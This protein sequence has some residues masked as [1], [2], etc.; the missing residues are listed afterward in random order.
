LRLTI[1][2]LLIGLF[3]SSGCRDVRNLQVSK[4]TDDQ[5]QSLEKKL[6]AEESGL[7]MGYMLRQTMSSAFGGSGIPQDITIRQAIEAQRAFAAK[8]KEDEIKADT[9]KAKIEAERK[10]KQEEF[11]KVLS[12]A[13]VAKKNTEGQ[14]G[15]KYVTFEMAF[16]NKTDKDIQGVKGVVK[17]SDIFGDKIKNIGFSYDGG[18]KAG[19]TAVYKGS[20]DVNRFDD[21]D[22][23]LYNTDL[24]K[25]KTSFETSVVIY[26]DGSKLDMPESND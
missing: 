19:K 1:A 3:V 20:V 13:V 12:E 7:L 11:A 21:K 15:Q 5:K 9:L 17:V 16:E 18:V 23:K 22:L 25:L 24:E 14:F 8:E 4:L 10:A 2:A 6:T 26:K